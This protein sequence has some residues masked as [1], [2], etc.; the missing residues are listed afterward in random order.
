LY[1]RS[2]LSRPLPPLRPQEAEAEAEAEEAEE[3][4]EEAVV[5]VAVEEKEEA[6][7]VERGSLWSCSLPLETHRGSLLAL[8]LLRWRPL[9]QHQPVVA[10]DSPP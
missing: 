8:L 1:L 9:Q 4:E 6:G 7:G 5:V 2:L 10:V 3:A